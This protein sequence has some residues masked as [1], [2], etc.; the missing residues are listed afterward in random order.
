MIRKMTKSDFESF[1]LVFSSV[2]QAQETYAFD[3]DMTLVEAYHLW[4]EMPLETYVF[5]ENDVVLGSYYIKPNAMGPGKHICN[6]GY[7]VAPEARGKGIARK[8]CEHSQQ[9]AFSLN[10]DAMQFN[11]VVSTNEVAVQLWQKL[12]FTIIGTIP[13]GYKHGQLGYV[14]SYVMYK[15]LGT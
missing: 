13:K 8:M 14:D 12:G 7:M 5:V 9:Q 1:W 6:C 2:I 15:Q 11:S 3:P 4:C 10:F